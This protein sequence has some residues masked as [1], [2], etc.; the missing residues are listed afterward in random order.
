MHAKQAR[1][2][3]WQLYLALPVFT[4]CAVIDT[5]LQLSAGGHQLLQ[6]AALLTAVGWVRVWLRTNASALRSMDEDAYSRSVI[7]RTY[8]A[9]RQSPEL[10]PNDPASS[11]LEPTERDAVD[12]R[13]RPA[14]GLQYKSK[15]VQQ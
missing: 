5:R 12:S 11:P 2:R 1:P 8:P 10:L 6:V 3:W 13:A 9:A 14:F 15:M 4:G 7:V